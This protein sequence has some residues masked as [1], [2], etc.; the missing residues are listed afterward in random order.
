MDG[1]G[2]ICMKS[3]R[4]VAI[5]AMALGSVGWLRADTLPADPL[6]KFTTG[7]GGSVDITCITNGCETDF[8][9]GPDGFLTTNIFNETGFNITGMNFVL[10]TTNFDQSFSAF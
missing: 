2:G 8:S 5:G 1:V 6:I 7:G 10:P 4:V 9:V 3:F